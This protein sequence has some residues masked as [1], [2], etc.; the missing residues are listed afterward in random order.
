[1]RSTFMKRTLHIR[2]HTGTK[3]DRYGPAHAERAACGNPRSLTE[4]ARSQSRQISGDDAERLLGAIRERPQKS[5]PR[6]VRIVGPRFHAASLHS[7]H[8][9]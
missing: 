9:H 3:R 8:S 5:N 4:A 7:V 1:M 2:T 6:A